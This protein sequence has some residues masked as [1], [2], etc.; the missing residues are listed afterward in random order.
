M[1]SNTKEYSLQYYH[2][3][4]NED[5]LCECGRQVLKYNIYRHRK[6][7]LHQ[8]YLAQQEI[9]ASIDISDVEIVT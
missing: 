4:K 6:S 3:N 2:A 1:G 9:I 8:A 5:R 7:K